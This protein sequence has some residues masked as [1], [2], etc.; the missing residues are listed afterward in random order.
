VGSTHIK[1]Q[2]KIIMNLNINT[3][4][5]VGEGRVLMPTFKEW[6]PSYSLKVEQIL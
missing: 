4:Q 1:A 6:D 5:G 3:S 2:G